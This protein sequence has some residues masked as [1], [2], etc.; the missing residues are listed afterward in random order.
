MKKILLILFICPTVSFSQSLNS[1][2]YK[3]FNFGIYAALSPSPYSVPAFPGA[4]FLWGKTNYYQN[5]RLLDY[6]IGIAFPTIITGKV[7]YGI[8]DQDYATIFGIRPFPTTTY[9]QFS[10]REKYNIAIEY[11]PIDFEHIEFGRG[12]LIICYGY[13]F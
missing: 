9:V 11:T 4:S 10:F 6:Q 1:N 8:G 13:R 7:G 12:G 5:N 2:S 3:E